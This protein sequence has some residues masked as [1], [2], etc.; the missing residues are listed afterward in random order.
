M[1]TTT[2]HF[3]NHN[4]LIKLASTSAA[5]A[6]GAVLVAGNGQTAYAATPVNGQADNSLTAANY[7]LPAANNQGGVVEQQLHQNVTRT[8]NITDPA[9]NVQT[10]QQ[11]AMLTG[12]QRFDQTHGIVLEGHLSNGHF[13]AVNIPAVNGYHASATVPGEVVTAGSQDQ[14]IN[15]HYFAGQGA[16]SQRPAK[17]VLPTPTAVK[18]NQAAVQLVTAPAKS[19]RKD[20]VSVSPK[21]DNVAGASFGLAGLDAMVAGLAGWHKRIH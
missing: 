3:S 9:G 16:N 10:I 20:S 6:L 5:L 11:T 2:H 21:Q 14:T 7:T 15:I 12:S 17:T 13:A 1:F 18:E 19:T 4:T 8:V